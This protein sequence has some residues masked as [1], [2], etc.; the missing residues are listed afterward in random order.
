MKC[1]YCGKSAK[2]RPDGFV[3]CRDCTEQNKVYTVMQEQA[4]TIAARDLTIRRLKEALRLISDPEN[5]RKVNENIVWNDR[6]GNEFMTEHAMIIAKRVL[7][8]TR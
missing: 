8:A 6:Y 2:R 1:I 3:V 7:R 5:W 4:E